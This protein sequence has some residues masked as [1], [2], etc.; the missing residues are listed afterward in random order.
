MMK[1]FQLEPF[2]DTSGKMDWVQGQWQK[3]LMMWKAQELSMNVWHKTSSEVSRK[4]M[5]LALK[6]NQGQRDLSLWKMSSY[7][8][9]LN[10]SQAQVLVHCQ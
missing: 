3:K 10:N 1:K 9:W 5:T 7:L 6:T 4:V 8:K 2:Y